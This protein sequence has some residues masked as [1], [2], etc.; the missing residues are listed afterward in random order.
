MEHS[1]AILEDAN[2]SIEAAASRDNPTESSKMDKDAA[3]DGNNEHPTNNYSRRKRKA[4]ADS[5]MRHGSKGGFD[6]RKRHKKGD[7]GRSEYL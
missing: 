6:N 4:F 5:S 7:L 3:A 2:K 1:A